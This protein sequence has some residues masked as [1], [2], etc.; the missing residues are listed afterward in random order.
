[1]NNTIT[2]LEQRMNELE[3]KIALRDLKTR[4]WRAVDR[5]ELDTVRR[6]LLAEAHIDMEGVGI[7]SGAEFIDFVERNGCKPGLYNL[8]SGQNCIITIQDRDNASGEWDMWFT[9]VDMGA[10]Q[11]IQM[12][13][14]YQDTY[15]KIGGEWK[16]A[17]MQFRQT[18]FLMHAYD[19]KA[20]PAALS[21]GRGNE[22]AFGT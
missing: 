3:A 18:S 1:M 13:G 15:K 17:S 4:Y 8:H 21:M 6:C 16:I 22:N 5:Q 9:S 14:D 10:R 20:K 7:M 11:T 2:A 19:D 12:T